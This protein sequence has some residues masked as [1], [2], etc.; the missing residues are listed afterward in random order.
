MSIQILKTSS[1]DI[2]EQLE[3]NPQRYVE[4]RAEILRESPH[5]AYHVSLAEEAETLLGRYYKE[6]LTNP[7]YFEGV[8]AITP[9]SLAGYY[10]LGQEVMTAA[11]MEAFRT[12]V[13]DPILDLPTVIPVAGSEIDGTWRRHPELAEGVASSSVEP[14]ESGHAE[15]ID[16]FRVYQPGCVRKHRMVKLTEEAV[17]KDQSND[18][19][20]QAALVGRNARREMYYDFLKVL[21]GVTNNFRMEANGTVQDHDT[22]QSA[23]ESLW[24]NSVSGVKLEDWSD[25]D[26]MEDL[27]SKMR[28]PTTGKPLEIQPKHI[29]VVR[30]KYRNLRRILSAT[31]IQ[32]NLTTDR[33]AILGNYWGA[34]LTGFAPLE[35]F[36]LVRQ[37]LATA[38]SDA[39]A[40]EHY[41]IGDF[42]KAF[43]KVEAEN[44]NVQIGEP[45]LVNRVLIT[46]HVKNWYAYWAMMPQAVAM[47]RDVA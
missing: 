42:S 45:D 4:K 24:V 10:T 21:F 28:H 30:G 37:H 13:D 46:Y 3:N 36:S 38:N 43:A 18:L 33:R 9:G 25:L 29:A 39:K 40:L 1:R 44:M 22:Y 20:D 32:E 34:Q 17:L 2:F 15:R 11:M 6:V 7:R 27:L 26:S 14:F 31:E 19:L 23:P 41:V 8:G 16:V 12:A 47:G 35:A 5:A